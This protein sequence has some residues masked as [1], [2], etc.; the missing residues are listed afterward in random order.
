MGKFLR[1][2]W[3]LLTTGAS[4]AVLQIPQ[5]I[6]DILQDTLVFRWVN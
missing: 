3:A 2:K 1:S 6:G 5:C 4:L